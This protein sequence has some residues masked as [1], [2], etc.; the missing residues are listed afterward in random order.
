MF[1]LNIAN[2]VTKSGT[3]N[4]QSQIGMFMSKYWASQLKF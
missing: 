2:Y 4:L 3:D 1:V